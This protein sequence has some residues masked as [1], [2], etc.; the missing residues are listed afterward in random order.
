MVGW[1]GTSNISRAEVVRRVH[2]LMYGHNS[3]SSMDGLRAKL[4]RKI[5]VQDKK[6]ASKSKID[7]GSPFYLPF[8]FEATPPAVEPLRS[9]IY[10]ALRYQTQLLT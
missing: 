5:V 6:L 1:N 7:P 10:Y 4:L 9:L 8:C 3:V 2:L